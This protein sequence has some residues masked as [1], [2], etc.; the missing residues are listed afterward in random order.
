MPFSTYAELQ[1]SIQNWI[2][3]PDLSA[4]QIQDF[5]ALGEARI[6]RDARIRA[7]EAAL[8]DTIASGVIAVP[9]DYV[10]MK[11]AYVDGSPTTKLTRQD[12]D[13]IYRKYPTRSSD[14][15]PKYFA[16]EGGN[17][18]FGPYPDSAYT[19]KGTYYK[20]LP[21]LSASNTT[22]WFTS[23]AP[24]VLLFASLAEAWS[25]IGD[26][27][28]EAKYDN[29]YQKAVN[30]VNLEDKRERRSG[31]AMSSTPG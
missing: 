6:Y 11:V 2:D 12:A 22:N 28:Q 1:T 26:D 13:Y 17:F 16:Q 10:A 27:E 3:R 7:M 23:N 8:S 9:A 14:T 4:A 31:S 21:A 24:D 5:I 15:K 20:R 18:I 25:F 29:R 30:M 19:I